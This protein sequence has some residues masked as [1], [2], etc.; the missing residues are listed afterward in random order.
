MMM[1]PLTT[2][3][4]NRARGLSHHGRPEPVDANHD[5]RGHD[6]PQLPNTFLAIPYYAG[7]R[8]IPGVDRPLG[9]KA[10]WYL[11]PAI[12]VNG[13]KGMNTFMRGE[14]TTVTVD[15]VDS[16]NGTT[17]A[18]V[19]VAVWWADPSTG[20]TKL[21]LFGQTS[22]AV[23]TDGVPRTSP[24]ITGVI[25]TSAPSHV[26]LVAR[27]SAPLDSPAPGAPIL[28]GDDRRWAQ[29]NINALAASMGQPFQFM[30]WA[31]NPFDQ[32]AD[33]EVIARAVE[34]EALSMLSRHVR[35]DL[36]RVRHMDLRLADRRAPWTDDGQHDARHRL[37]LEP[38]ERRP[39][40][41]T[42][43]LPDDVEPD[44]AAAIEILQVAP[45][46][47]ESSRVVGSIG[48]VVT[49]KRRG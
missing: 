7:D 12:V 39:I 31:G 3:A 20:F 19:Q 9:S 44:R 47:R 43:V 16:G 41:L 37:V 42:G 34:G 18:P 4:W 46:E 2:I 13:I 29:L 14:P 8:G 23:P 40:M 36:V 45:G 28:P 32:A 6:E 21:T 27:V 26:C 11:C 38:G 5:D 49:A 22:L 15:V 33:F 17:A 10:V 48:L 35:A 25:P 24:T 30:F 1:T